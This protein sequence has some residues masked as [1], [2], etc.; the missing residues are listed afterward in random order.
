MKVEELQSEDYS[1][2]EEY[3]KNHEG[4]MFY[5]SLKY[6]SFIKKLL[7]CEFIIY[8]VFDSDQVIQ[9]AFPTMFKGGKYGYV[10]NSLPFYGSHGG[11]LTS[12]LEAEVLLIEKF[13]S[14]SVSSEVAVNMLVS[15]PNFSLSEI[16][17]H[18]Y[19]DTRIGQL[20]H[21]GY[22]EDIGDSLM[23]SFHS[24]TRNMIRKSMK[25][26]LM[27]SIDNSA[28]DFLE[29]IHKENMEVIGGQEKSHEFFQL[30]PEFFEQGTDYDLY[31]AS[32]EGESIA[33]M[34]VFYYKDV[35]EY[36]TPVVKAQY[37][38]FQPLSLLIYQA[39][40]DSAGRS[41]L[42][43]NWGG[44]WLSQDGVYRFKSRFGAIDKEYKYY[45]SVSNN[46]ILKAEAQKLLKEYEGFYTV[47]FDKLEV[48]NAPN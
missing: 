15:N 27:V 21:I 16:P 34:L 32:K 41:F 17:K 25:S 22:K 1:K 28:F 3:V 23:A 38:N 37:R 18:N 20:T 29:E 39:M 14:I 4:G 42:W 35:V 48:D 9:G 6:L 11:F 13:N 47:P 5:Y 2:Y 33:A 7:G 36:Y 12:T 19:Q 24:K 45:V 30:V 26:D 40:I 44:T 31:I 8:A 43:W 10:Y 46:N